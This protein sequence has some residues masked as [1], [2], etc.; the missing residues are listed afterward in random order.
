MGLKIYYL[1]GGSSPDGSVTF[2][3][4]ECVL[5]VIN[6]CKLLIGDTSSDIVGRVGDLAIIKDTKK[7]LFREDSQWIEIL[8]EQGPKGDKGDQ[9]P[10]GEPGSPKDAWPIDSIFSCVVDTD[11]EKLLGFGKWECIQKEPWYAWQR[12]E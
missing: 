6:R 1:V 12:K 3:D 7:F 9:G 4:D 10:Q 11:P 8:G 5:P 2:Y